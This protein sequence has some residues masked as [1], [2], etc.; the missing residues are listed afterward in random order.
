MDETTVSYIYAPSAGNVCRR[1]YF[2]HRRLPP[3]AKISQGQLRS[4]V[5]H[6]AFI[7]P[8]AALQRVLPQVLIGSKSRFTLRVLNR[9]GKIPSTVHII[10]GKTAWNNGSIML[11]IL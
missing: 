3:V 10:R 5:T 8:H 2:P 1:R 9:L 6:C 11:Q 4:T 7:A